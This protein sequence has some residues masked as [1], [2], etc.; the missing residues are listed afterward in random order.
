MRVQKLIN[1]NMKIVDVGFVYIY[2]QTKKK[3]M[4]K[5]R[6]VKNQV[7]TSFMISMSV[8]LVNAGFDH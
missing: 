5:K 6:K 4:K 1:Y 7:E 3:K 2:R 8:E